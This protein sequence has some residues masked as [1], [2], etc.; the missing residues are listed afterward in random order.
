MSYR[1]IEGCRF[2]KRH[3]PKNKQEA[4]VKQDRRSALFLNL[5]AIALIGFLTACGDEETN[6]NQADISYRVPPAHAAVDPPEVQLKR[7]S[8][9]AVNQG[10][11]TTAETIERDI[12]RFPNSP[13]VGL[14][15]YIYQ[16]GLEYGIDPAFAAAIFYSESHHADVPTSIARL[17]F[18]PGSL[19]SGRGGA[20]QE[21]D[22]FAYFNSYEEGIEAFYR[23]IRY[24]YFD[25]QNLLT[26]D[27]ILWL[28]APPSENDTRGYINL[29]KSRMKS[30]R[31]ESSYNPNIT[32]ERQNYPS[33]TQ[34]GGNR[35][36]CPTGQIVPNKAQMWAEVNGRLVLSRYSFG[37]TKFEE[38]LTGV[39]R[40]EEGNI[41]YCQT[42][43][44]G[45]EYPVWHRTQ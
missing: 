17:N 22:G 1:G 15:E 45:G 34:A 41:L 7:E 27:E 21:R 28:Y 9:W 36:A 31:E 10:S 29:I 23:H 2:I 8:Y 20:T 40:V 24:F 35:T 44:Q 11:T 13:M 37:D 42:D 38:R 39:Q 26:V 14:G 6:P 32:V 12:R 3:A 30:L 18:N 33:N 43:F 16:K 5:I 4:S 25:G 19:R